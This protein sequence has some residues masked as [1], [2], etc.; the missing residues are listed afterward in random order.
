MST[1]LSIDQYLSAV[2]PALVTDENKAVYI[3]MATERTNKCFYGEKYNQAVALLAAHIAFLLTAASSSMG[4][5][6]GSEEAG[7]TGTITSKREGDLSV[8]YG[9]GAVSASA[10][11]VTDAELSQTRYGLMLLALRKGCKPFMGVLNGGR[12]CGRC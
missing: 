2:A 7:S 6:S 8:T 3:E 4:A 11:D 5:G 9:A 12:G 1:P 10:A